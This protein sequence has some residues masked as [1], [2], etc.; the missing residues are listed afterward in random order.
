L[1]RNAQNSDIN[2]MAALEAAEP[3]GSQWSATNLKEDLSKSGATVL[4][5]EKSGVFAGH[6][7]AWMIAG[8]LEIM[9]IAVHPDYRRQGIGGALLAAL[10]ASEGHNSAFLEIRESN[11]AAMRL[12]QKSGFEI[13]GRRTAYYRDGEDALLMRLNAKKN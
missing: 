4:D 11:K 2:A 12:Y 6:A 1:I 8:D 13:I 7:V 9:T 3:M 10:L 5:S